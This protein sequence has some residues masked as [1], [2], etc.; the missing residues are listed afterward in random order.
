MRCSPGITAPVARHIKLNFT[1]D[2]CGGFSSGGA[3]T[4]TPTSFPTPLSYGLLD[5]GIG[6]P[7]PDAQEAWNDFRLA[8][9]SGLASYFDIKRQSFSQALAPASRIWSTR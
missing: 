4:K 5:Q 3:I 6:L 2:T 7:G 9:P 1:S 8:L